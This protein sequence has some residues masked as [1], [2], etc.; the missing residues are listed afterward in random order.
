MVTTI[1]YEIKGYNFYTL[2]VDW[3]LFLKCNGDDYLHSI[4]SLMK[5][6]RFTKLVKIKDQ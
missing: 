1:L 3:E 5:P 2:P 4:F 6:I